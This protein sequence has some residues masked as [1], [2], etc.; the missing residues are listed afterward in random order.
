[1]CYWGTEKWMNL[2]ELKYE[3]IFF[4]NINEMKQIYIQEYLFLC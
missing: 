2:T 1:M 3:Y 4:I